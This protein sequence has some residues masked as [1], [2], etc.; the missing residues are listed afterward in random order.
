VNV[1][2]GGE[3]L[4]VGRMEL[5]RLAETVVVHGRAPEPPPAPAFSLKP[6]PVHDRE[7]ICAPAK[8]RPVPESLGTI[9]S[10]R[11][12]TDHALFAQGDELMIDGG[13]LTGLEVGLNVAVRRNFRV[14]GAT[15]LV[16]G[17][18]TSGLVQIVSVGDRT[19]LAIVVYTC[20]TMM[21]GDFL[22]TFEPKPGYQADGSG[23]PAYEDAARIL[24]ADEGRMLAAPDRMMVIDR[25]SEQG[26]Y[27]GQ[28]VTLFRRIATG[29]S[30]RSSVVGEAI[31]VA[32]RPDSATI[33]VKRVTGAIEAGDWAAPQR[34]S[35]AA[36]SA[37]LQP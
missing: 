23:V 36:V 22:A 28:R 7:S 26:M 20:D 9:R 30:S 35:V 13:T 15:G 4:V 5:A 33:R 12:G 21:K 34:A 32:V 10:H 31:L 16:T 17:E 27:P 24:F 3:S 14:R 2:P 8:A 19:S 6:V 18:H 37:L 11:R 25:G 1:E 29:R